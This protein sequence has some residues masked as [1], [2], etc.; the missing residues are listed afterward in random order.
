MSMQQ[1]MFASLAA[2][3]GGYV[4]NGSGLF[5]GTN[6]YLTRT[7]SAG[8]SKTFTISCV[9]KRSELSA[10]NIIFVAGNFSAAYL[11]AYFN[12]ADQLIVEDYTGSGG[13][14]N[15]RLDSNQ[16]FRD[17]SAWYHM[18]IKY[19]STAGTPSASDN[20]VFINGVQIT[21]F[22]GTETY[23]DQNDTSSW[24]TNVAHRLGWGVNVNS[25]YYL[26]AYVA[27]FAH[28]EGQ[29]LNADSFG[30]F[31]D[32]GFWQINDSSGLT[33]G[34]NGF[35]LEGGSDVVAGTDSSGNDND[36][37]KSGTVTATNDSATNGDA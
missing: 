7:P 20:G 9:F 13:V 28:I 36:F 12:A 10:I 37:T 31:T 26:N 27:Q 33:F 22:Q 35:L 2:G 18:V 1:I 32:D 16:V 5:N 11:G 19:N 4:I 29:A 3:G 17:P 30:E 15:L 8:N 21:D 23:P 24:N 25:A 14:F 6:G 34:T